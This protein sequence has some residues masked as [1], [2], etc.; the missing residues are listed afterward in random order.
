MAFLIGDSPQWTYVGIPLFATQNAFSAAP[1][2]ISTGESEQVD[3][4]ARNHQFFIRADDAHG[5]PTGVRGNFCG[6]FAVPCLVQFNT[7]EFQPF[8]NACANQW[9]IFADTAGEAGGV[10]KIEGGSLNAV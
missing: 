4:R 1:E 9:H 3:H 2:L 5:N 7:E 6:V 10:H 8:T